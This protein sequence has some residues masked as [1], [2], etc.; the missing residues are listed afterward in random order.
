MGNRLAEKKNGICL[1]RCKVYPFLIPVFDGINFLYSNKHRKIDYTFRNLSF[2]GS[3]AIGTPV[4][5]SMTELYVM[6]RYL[7]PDLLAAA[8]VERFDDWAAT[9][10]KVTTQYKQSATGEL[11]LKTAFAKFANLPELMAI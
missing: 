1:H 2:S 10:G 9:F 11:K 5:N 3:A 8:G 7:R 6:L 4:S